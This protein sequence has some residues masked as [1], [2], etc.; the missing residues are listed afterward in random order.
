MRQ[1]PVYMIWGRLQWGGDQ[2][3]SQPVSNAFA[4]D[5]QAGQGKWMTASFHPKFSWGH[6]Q[7]VDCIVIP[8]GFMLKLPIDRTIL[9]T[10]DMQVTV[11]VWL[12]TAAQRKNTPL[13]SEL[14]VYTYFPGTKPDTT[15]LVPQNDYLDDWRY[16]VTSRSAG[17]MGTFP[18][19]LQ[20]RERA[21][22]YYAREDWRV[23]LQKLYTA[24]SKQND[25]SHLTIFLSFVYAEA[26][27]KKIENY[28]IEAPLGL[29]SAPITRVSSPVETISRSFSDLDFAEHHYD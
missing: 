27:L 3:D 5:A 26:Q 11:S 1:L 10:V 23:I 13:S 8:K 25:F 7:Q 28:K 14:H 19:T 18:L 9:S 29:S 24:D 2:K 15:Q 16:D 22:I 4:W 20:I 12:V 6:T 17:Y 21:A